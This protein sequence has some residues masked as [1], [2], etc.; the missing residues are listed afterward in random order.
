MGVILSTVEHVRL[1]RGRHLFHD[2]RRGQG[3]DE[4][5]TFGPEG[6]TLGLQRLDTACVTSGELAIGLGP[7]FRREFVC[8]LEPEGVADLFRF[9]D[10]GVGA[11][12]RDLAI[13]GLG[14]AVGAEQP[15]SLG[16][17]AG[18]TVMAD[19]RGH[20]LAVDEQRDGRSV[21]RALDA[22]GDLM[23]VSG[24]DLRTDRADDCCV[25]WVAL[26]GGPLQF[27]ADEA[28]FAPA[29]VADRGRVAGAVQGADD[30][31]VG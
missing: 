14:L 26:A 4:S 15:V 1:A 8:R 2:H 11:E 12:A 5:E 10:G 30:R 18:H 24:A 6:V 25:S 27:L 29:A 13:E 22:N 20:F 21:F 9:Q 23:P 16:G 3:A 17:G 31:G 19:L 28:E 7:L